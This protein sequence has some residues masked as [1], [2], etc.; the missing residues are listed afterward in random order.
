MFCAFVVN[1]ICAVVIDWQAFIHEFHQQTA[2]FVRIICGNGG[3]VLL[4]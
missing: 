4:K 1:I 3:C 2:L